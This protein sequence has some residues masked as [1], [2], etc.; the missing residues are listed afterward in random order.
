MYAFAFKYVIDSLTVSQL[1]DAAHNARIEME[2]AQRRI[3]DGL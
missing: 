1:K 3:Q 2:A